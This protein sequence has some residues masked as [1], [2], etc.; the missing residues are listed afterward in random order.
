MADPPREEVAAAVDLCRKASIRIVMVTGDYG[1][2]AVSI[3][4][5]IGIVQGKILVWL[6][7]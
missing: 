1:L 2:T 7:V 3:A 4:K 5:R 6:L